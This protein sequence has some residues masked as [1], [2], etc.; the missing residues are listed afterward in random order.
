MMRYDSKI[1]EKI[2]SDFDDGKSK[3]QLAR[4]YDIPRSTIKYWV[5]NKDKILHKL[6]SIENIDT[7]IQNINNKKYAYNI[8]LGLYLG[9]GHISNSGKSYRLRISQDLKYED[10]IL[11]IYN[12]LKFFFR[13]EPTIETRPGY[14]I[15][16][17]YNKNL[18]LYFP[19]LGTGKKYERKIVLVDYQKE[20]LE[21]S[22]LLKGLFI[23]DGSFYTAKVSQ[24]YFYERYN[25]TNKSVCILN[26]FE[27]CL[28]FFNISFL[29]NKR[30]D[31]VWR[32]QIQKKS[33]VEKM[34]NIVGIKS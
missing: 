15:I 13:T 18:P 31:D 7:I 24:K 27:E 34:K 26:L 4:D 23:S 22:A 19:H 14:K 32:I 6:N 3:N 2:I 25:F 17:I 33:E 9:D 12:L 16:S 11:E 10:S 5:N 30:N 20:N 8:L 21:P 29:K 1:I 28:N